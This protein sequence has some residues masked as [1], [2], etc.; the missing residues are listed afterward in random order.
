MRLVVTESGY[1][2]AARACVH[3]NHAVALRYDQLVDELASYGAMAGDASTSADF[4]ATYDD[5]ADSAV[6]A[7]EDLVEAFTTVGR[8][9]RASLAN[10]HRAEQRSI[11]PGAVVFD[12]AALPDED[13]Y[14]AVLPA[15]PPSALGGDP[16]SLPN[17]LTWILDQVESFV[18]PDADIGKLRDAATTW[19]TA[20]HSL[21]AVVDHH[22]L[23]ISALREEVS[24]EIPVAIGVVRE[25]QGST[26]ALVEQYSVL[27]TACDHYAD[28]V[29]QQRTA[30]L[31]LLHDLV[32]DTVIIAGAG[33]ALSVLTAGGSVAAATAATAARI[34]AAAPRLEVFVNLVRAAAATS[35]AAIRTAGGTLARVRD[36]LA[37]FKGVVIASDARALTAAM[38]HRELRVS[39]RMPRHFDPQALRGMSKRDIDGL[40]H[41]WERH[42]P[43]SGHGV[44]YED[45]IHNGRQIRVMDGYPGNRPSQ[46]THGP[47]AVVSQNGDKFK[48]PLEGN[49]FP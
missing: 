10:H 13:T 48:I 15:T 11:L 43:R 24:P 27:A 14:A 44:V 25:L 47:Y 16:G 22:D 28:Q 39:I 23:V 41:N 40:I 3:A 2:S 19:R 1:S 4:A 34:A 6:G 35:A 37:R 26:C 29:E 38:K 32:R 33:A 45:P 18:W 7:L 21:E 49:P 46:L 17:A 42:P 31:D 12:G 8:L 20:R 5:A 9:T 30:I 36:S